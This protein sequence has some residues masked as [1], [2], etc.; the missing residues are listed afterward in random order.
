MYAILS[1][2]REGATSGQRATG[3]E[4][5]PG[6]PRREVQPRRGA[7]C[8]FQILA[9]SQYTRLNLRSVLPGGSPGMAFCRARDIE[10]PRRVLPGVSFPA[11]DCLLLWPT[12]T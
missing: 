3:P 10:V 11:S 12:G 2:T 1:L 9:G 7:G 4:N 6:H 5:C 8:N